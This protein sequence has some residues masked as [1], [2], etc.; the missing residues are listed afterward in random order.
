MG[1]QEQSKREGPRRI[2][3][4]SDEEIIKVLKEINET[5]QIKER[6]PIISPE[7][8]KNV[9]HGRD[10]KADRT[11]KMRYNQKECK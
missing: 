8:K 3:V 6:R 10:G 2:V 11:S 4:N 1:E 9:K 7:G 5:L